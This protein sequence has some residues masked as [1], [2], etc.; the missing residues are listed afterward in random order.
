MQGLHQ[1]QPHPEAGPLKL[2]LIKILSFQ[3]LKKIDSPKKMKLRAGS[4]FERII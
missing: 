1:I 4:N 3:S 2:A